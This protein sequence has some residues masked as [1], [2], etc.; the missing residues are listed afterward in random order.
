MWFKCPIALNLD[1]PTLAPLLQVKNLSTSFEVEGRWQPVIRQISFSVNAGQTLGLIGESGCGKSVTSLALMRL[2]PKPW[3]RI[4]SGEVHLDGRDL[5]TLKPETFR[6]VRGRELAMI[7]QDPMTSLNPVMTIGAQLEEVLLRNPKTGQKTEARAV[8]LLRE[9]GIP[10]PKARLK[11]FP[12]ELSGGM[13]QRVMIAMALACEPKVLIA[14]EPTTALDVT[15]QAQI[16]A[17]LKDLQQ[18]RQMAM[19]LIT[20]DL[21]VVAQVCDE[22]AVMYGGRLVERSPTAHFFQHPRHPYSAGLINSIKSLTEPDRKRLATIAGQVPQLGQ[23]GK[24]CV[25]SGRCER[26]QSDCMA[27]HPDLVPD[28][29][30]RDLAC[31]HPME[32]R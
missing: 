12:H 16:L 18:R 14:D 20:H 10:D 32:A 7:F 25:F 19:I 15:I 22:V 9:V 11:A 23:F 13:K 26:A 30:E 28:L 2:I 1:F 17:L 21:G 31:Y 6:Q 5:M 8:E 24:G 27:A 29:A 3:G 4:D